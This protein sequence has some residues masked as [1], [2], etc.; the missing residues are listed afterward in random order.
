MQL[1]KKYVY[2][3]MFCETKSFGI[4]YICLC[5]YAWKW[6]DLWNKI[7][8]SYM[9]ISGMKIK[10]VY[11][12]R[13]IALKYFFFYF[14][15][16]K[17]HRNNINITNTKCSF[18]FFEIIFFLFFFA[19]QFQSFLLCAFWVF[20]IFIYI[21]FFL[22]FFILCVQFCKLHIILAFICSDKK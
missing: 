7:I 2:E 5:Q 12:K 19:L 15:F 6:N 18:I 14:F 9:L 3:F 20:C 22:F 13:H 8:S 10:S 16:D 11:L 4:I 1:E 21:F 17:Q